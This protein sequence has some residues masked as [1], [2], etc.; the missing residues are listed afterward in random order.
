MMG[1][2]ANGNVNAFFVWLSEEDEAEVMRL[3]AIGKRTKKKRIKRKIA[4]RIDTFVPIAPPS[5]PM[6]STL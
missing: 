3:H 2:L 4:K 5:K 1:Y 6:I